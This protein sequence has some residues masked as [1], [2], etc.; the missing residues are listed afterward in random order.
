[1][2]EEKF[3]AKLDTEAAQRELF[4]WRSESEPLRP[5]AFRAKAKRSGREKAI[6]TPN[7]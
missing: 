3:K 6:H 2:S 1:M 7:C 4:G 5:E